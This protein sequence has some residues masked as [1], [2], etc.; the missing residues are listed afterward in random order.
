MP[1]SGGPTSLAMW[2]A[3]MVAVTPF[4]AIALL[5][6]IIAR[7]HWTPLAQL[8]EHYLRRYPLFAAGLAGFFGALVGHVFWSYGDNPPYPPAPGYLFLFGVGLAVSS[9]I[10]GALSLAMLGAAGAW[11]VG[12]TRRV[13][14]QGRAE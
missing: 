10:V 7:N 12:M 13:S 9:G 1:Q 3:A 6:V 11:L 14:G 5:N 8:V 4:I 2:F